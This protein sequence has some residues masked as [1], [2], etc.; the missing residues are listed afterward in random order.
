MDLMGL[1]SLFGGQ[2]GGGMPGM[3]FLQL[4]QQS[5]NPQLQG[6]TG[7]N[8][9]EEAGGLQPL[10]LPPDPA[11]R[12]LST[13]LGKGLQGMGGQMMKQGAAQMAQP[14]KPPAA[15]PGSVAPFQPMASAYQA[16]G[17]HLKRP[18]GPMMRSPFMPM[19][20]Q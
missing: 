10:S 16:P 8:S 2:G 4:L 20:G 14:M 11:R 7:P 15:T 3:G 19:R 9:V 1:A 12:E 13:G 17:S 6:S 18:Q 5:M